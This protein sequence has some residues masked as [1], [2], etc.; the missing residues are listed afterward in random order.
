MASDGAAEGIAA[1]PPADRCVEPSPLAELLRVHRRFGPKGVRALSD[2]SLRLRRGEKV[3]VVGP[4]GS[5]KSTLLHLLSGLD[6]PT[7]GRVVF[8]GR[9]PRST[10]EWAGIRARRIGFVFQAFHLLPALTAAE[11]VE[12]AL[13]GDGRGVSARSRRAAE[14]LDA[15]GLGDRLHHRPAELSGGE[16]QRVA[17]ARSLANEPDLVLADEPTGNLDLESS[18]EVLSLLDD[19]RRKSGTTLVVVT[20]S[21]EVAAGADRVVRLVKGSI[22]G[23]GPGEG[24]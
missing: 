1:R 4:S 15:V 2:V 8:D 5:G 11:N 19:L 12:V 7:E 13:F 23:E 9:E 22:L 18:T 10:K 17:I 24:S 20:H 14:L 21:P 6:R 3:A 16:C